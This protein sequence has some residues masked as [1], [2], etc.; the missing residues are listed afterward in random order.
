MS[1]TVLAFFICVSVPLLVTATQPMSPAWSEV[2]FRTD[3][4]AKQPISVRAKITSSGSVEFAVTSA[5]GEFTWEEKV[6]IP[7]LDTLR[8]SHYGH[9]EGGETHGFVLCMDYGRPVRYQYGAEGDPVWTYDSRFVE[10]RFEG[11]VRVATFFDN[12]G[13]LPISDCRT[14]M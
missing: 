14:S 10:Y 7:K 3:G 9:V 5:H 8:L 2:S 4:P 12:D 13:V 11:V 1:K 6:D